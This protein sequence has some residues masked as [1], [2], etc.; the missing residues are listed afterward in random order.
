MVA[1]YLGVVEVAGSNPVVPIFL[2]FILLGVLQD[3]NLFIFI[4]ELSSLSFGLRS[5][6]PVVPIFLCFIL[7]GVVGWVK[8]NNNIE[9]A[10]VGCSC[11]C[12]NKIPS[13]LV[14]T[15]VQDNI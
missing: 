8:P 12:T 3:L 11:Y 4:F 5:K 15:T 13:L 14:G 6:S 1:C 2:C 9:V 7:P 10:K